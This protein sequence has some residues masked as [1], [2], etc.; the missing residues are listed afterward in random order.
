MYK[1]QLY[2]NTTGVN[3]ISIGKESLY[4]TIT[5]SYLVAI[6]DSA[7]Y[8]NGLSAPNPWEATA[9]IAIGYQ[10]MALNTVGWDNISIGVK[11]ARFNTT[12]ARNVVVGNAALYSNTTVSYTHLDV[13]KRQKLYLPM[14]NPVFALR[15]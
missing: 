2:S 13:Y 15:N 4:K 12:G 1:R 3:N 10:S 6:G 11:S 8:S 7:L 5:K 9:N 14:M